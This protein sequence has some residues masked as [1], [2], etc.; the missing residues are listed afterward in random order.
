MS[1]PHDRRGMLKM[2][3]ALPLVLGACA[4]AQPALADDDDDDDDDDDRRRRRRRR[5]RS[6]R[7]EREVW[8]ELEYRPIRR[9][10]EWRRR[11]W[12]FE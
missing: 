12:D 8:Y 6:S 4:I 2:L 3:F 10:P 7:R 5:R 11:D 9:R 1:N